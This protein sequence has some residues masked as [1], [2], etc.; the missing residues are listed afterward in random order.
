MG[1]SMGGAIAFYSATISKH[2]KGIIPVIGS[3]SFVEFAKYKMQVN[4]WSEEEYKTFIQNLEM[5]DPLNRP[6]IFKKIKV[7]MLTGDRD[8]RV[9]GI[10]AKQLQESLSDDGSSDDHKLI[11]YDAE[12]E[13]TDKMIKDILAW[14]VAN[15]L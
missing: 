4:N 2:V 9:P 3:P 13:V 12:H 1:I 11:T 8:E 10:W 5:D 15:L 6:E 14:G 7:L